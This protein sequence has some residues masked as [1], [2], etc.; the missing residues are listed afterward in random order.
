MPS[1]SLF[2]W[3]CVSSASSMLG[4]M[5]IPWRRKQQPTPVVLPGEFCGLRSLVGCSPRGHKESD[6]TERQTTPTTWQ[7]QVLEF[8]L[9]GSKAEGKKPFKLAEPWL[10]LSTSLGISFGRRKCQHLFL[11]ASL[12]AASI[13]VRLESRQPCPCVRN[14]LCLIICFASPH[15]RTPLSGPHGLV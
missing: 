2:P 3:S 5:K 14:A 13:T 9:L 12:E 15:L 8:N 4:L 7:K 1:K 10:H 11:T 6:M